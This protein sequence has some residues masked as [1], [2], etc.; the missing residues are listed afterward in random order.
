MDRTYGQVVWTGHSCNTL[1]TSL[2]CSNNSISLIYTI[3]TCVC[4][5]V[6]V[7]VCVCVCFRFSQFFISPL[8]TVDATDRE[9]NAV[10]SGEVTIMAPSVYGQLTY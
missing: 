9:I 6:C 10:D 2:H 1:H 4:L 8:F 5:Y 3:F 7:C